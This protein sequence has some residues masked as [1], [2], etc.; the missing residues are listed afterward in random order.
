MF[1][2]SDALKFEVTK[3]L[4]VDSGTKMSKGG[5]WTTWTNMDTF[6]HHRGFHG[7]SWVLGNVHMAVC[8]QLFGVPLDE[9]CPPTG[10]FLL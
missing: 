2:V 9:G 7:S 8:V 4:S 10:Q 3:V 1:F 6:P 5:E